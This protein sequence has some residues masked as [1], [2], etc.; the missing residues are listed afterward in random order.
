MKLSIFSSLVILNLICPAFNLFSQEKVLPHYE[1]QKI[2]IHDD[3]LVKKVNSTA[4]VYKD[5][6]GNLV[7]SNGLV[8]RTFTL[9]PNVATVELDNLRTGES[10]LRAIK[11]EAEIQIDGINFKIGGLTGQKVNNYFLP[12]WYSLLSAEPFSFKMVSY[13]AKPVSE[14]FPWKKRMEW[15]SKDVQWPTPGLHLIFSYEASNEL[16]NDLNLVKGEKE[17]FDYLKGVMVNIHY[18]LYNE[19]PIFC[20][21]ITVENKS[22]Q[23]ITINTF[24]SEILAC[25]EVENSEENSKTY[26][27]TP[28][29]TIETDYRFGGENFANVTR[30]SINWSSDPEYT[31]QLVYSTVPPQCLLEVYPK[32]GPAQEVKQNEMFESFRTWEILN[33]NLDR[34]RKGLAIRRLYRMLAPW[35]LENPIL[36]HVRYADNESVKK[37]IDQCAEVGFEMV[38]MTFGSGFNLE[39]T[40]SKNIDRMKTL[41]DY[42]H[43]KGVALGGYSL[44]ASRTISKEDDVVMPIGQK[45]RWGGSP[46]LV[47]KWG[48]EYFDKLY[49]FYKATGMDVLEHDGSY[50]G[51]V[52]ASDRHPG[53]KGLE[54]SQWKQFRKIK[55][56]YYWCRANGIYLNVPDAYFMAGSNKNVM[57]Y[58]E[59]GMRLPR[60]QQE[61]I[62]RQNIYD[63]TWDKTPSMGWMFVPLTEYGGGG[64]EATVEP[65]KE[66]L[67][68]YG[69]RLANLFGAGVQACYRGPQ[70]YDAPETKALVEKWV[71]FYKKHRQILDGDIIHIRRAD[72]RDFD[73]ILHVDPQGDEKGL[74]MV[75]NPL[76]EQITRNLDIPVYYTGLNGKVSVREQE[77]KAKT[78]SVN[79]DYKISL[80]VRIPAKGYNYYILK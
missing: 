70:L 77:G 17:K 30:T 25:P 16:I 43:S 3:W 39:N 71:G 46:C 26:L 8:S 67:H 66:H 45:P 11:P 76:E 58:R 6:Y 36:M 38:I 53:H 72:G 63:A 52:C 41:A 32:I 51:D 31:T 60:E 18:E 79:Q 2:A 65:L 54:D 47:S 7:L 19:V 34:E 20:K 15:L 80:T 21:W 56:F 28:N 29:I 59:G 61:I 55:N 62:E 68:H 10:F 12:E 78:F 35:V 69:Q 23:Q 24:K 64:P 40:D 22:G 74:L 42:A 48:I 37:A 49:N 4:T 44:L 57:G 50:P 73:A 9:Q 75:Y 33:D 5:K 27:N 1:K 13:E 14:R